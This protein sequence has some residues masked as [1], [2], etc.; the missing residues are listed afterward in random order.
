MAALV[1]SMT[2]RRDD[3]PHTGGMRY[4]DGVGRVP[5][6]AISILAAERLADALAH[7]PHLKVEL[8]LTCDTLP[9]EPSANVLGDL[10]G[11]E[12]PGEVVVIGGHL[13]CWD[14]GQGAHD[15]GAGCV[16]AS[17]RSGS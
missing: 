14:K 10:V 8:K 12:R 17:R 7:N 1:R 2:A 5:A 3:V 4:A 9:D 15:D 13:D 16:H 11:A 6:A